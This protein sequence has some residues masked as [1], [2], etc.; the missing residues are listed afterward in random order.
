MIDRNR[1]RKKR[2]TAWLLEESLP[3]SDGQHTDNRYILYHEKKMA[4]DAAY[5]EYVEWCKFHG[6][7]PMN[8]EGFGLIRSEEWKIEEKLRKALK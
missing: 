5:E 7:T 2:R 8:K 1:S 6:E 4:D 3:K